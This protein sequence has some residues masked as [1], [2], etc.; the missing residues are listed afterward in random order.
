W[1]FVSRL[2]LIYLFFANIVAVL[3]VRLLMKRALMWAYRRG[4]GVRKMV[5]IG[6]TEA[7]AAVAKT[8]ALHPELGYRVI[9]ALKQ[10][11]AEGGRPVRERV[12]LRDAVAMLEREDVRD[13]VLTVPVGQ[14]EELREFII[15]CQTRGIEV[16]LVPD[17]YELYS[18][19]MHLDGI[20]D[21]PLL[22]FRRA[23]LRGW[24]R[25]AKRGLDLAIASV[26][27]VITSP[28][29][30]ALATA[31]RYRTGQPVLARHPRVG[32]M[33]RQFMMLRFATTAS[34]PA[35]VT[36]YSLSE[37]PQLVNVLRG[38]M[39]LVGPRPE[40]PERLARYSAWHRRR[41]L[42]GPGI[43]GLAQV[44]GLRG[45]D[46]TDEKTRFDLQYIERQSLL[47]DLKILLQTIWTLMRRGRQPL[48][49]AAQSSDRGVPPLTAGEARRVEPC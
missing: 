44:N 15:A 36:R 2:L 47:L 30:L 12:G 38:D 13:I 41:L 25:A 43:T 9:G 35:W 4:I 5:V 40:E 19:S 20:E 34:V 28:A 49:P 23:S 39:S 46:S 26:L 11:T 17:L 48:P 32:R 42:V 45:F 33:G 27:I 8:A 6:A 31:I 24:E 16:R 37:L 14:N 3:A 22:G 21:I 18:S 1:F 29:W 10:E 7:A